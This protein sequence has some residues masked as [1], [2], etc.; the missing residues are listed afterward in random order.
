MPRP[1]WGHGTTTPVATFT[2]DEIRKVMDKHHPSVLGGH[3][4][5]AC[6]CG[7][8]TVAAQRCRYCQAPVDQ[9]DYRATR[10]RSNCSRPSGFPAVGVTTH[11]YAE[12]TVDHLVE[13]LKEARGYG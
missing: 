8:E 10:H 12:F 5:V 9:K 3:D 11:R 6:T 4:E 1:D 2:E 7:P 13:K